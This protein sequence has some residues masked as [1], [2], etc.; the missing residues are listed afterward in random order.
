M[1]D[2]ELL[3][4][5]VCPKDQVPLAL[6]DEPLMAKVNEA[7]AAGRITNLAGQTVRKTLQGGLVREDKT[8]LYPI[9]DDI[10]VLL[11]DEAIPL[12]QLP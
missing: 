7:I 11:T 12:R 2:K 8:L 4:I 9:V 10:P 6:A 3:D 1:I 5:L